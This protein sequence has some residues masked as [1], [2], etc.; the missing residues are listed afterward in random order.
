[1]DNRFEKYPTKHHKNMLIETKPI[2]KKQQNINN[3]RKRN[4]HKNMII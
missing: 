3:E 1:M 4:M 2:T